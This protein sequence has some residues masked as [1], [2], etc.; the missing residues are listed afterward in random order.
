ML[1]HVKHENGATRYGM[2]KFHS[3]KSLKIIRAVSRETLEADEPLLYNTNRR[4]RYGK[5]HFY[6]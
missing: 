2:G 1:F 4:C 5:N 3:H 6:F